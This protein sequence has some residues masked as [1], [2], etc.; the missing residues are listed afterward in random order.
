MIPRW[1]LAVFF[2]AVTRPMPSMTPSQANIV[3]AGYGR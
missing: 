2:L 3:A 1:L